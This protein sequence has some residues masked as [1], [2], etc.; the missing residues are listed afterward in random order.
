M[1]A[2]PAGE[3]EFIGRCHERL[4]RMLAAFGTSGDIGCL[5]RLTARHGYAGEAVASSS[6]NRDGR[7]VDYFVCRLTPGAT[8][9]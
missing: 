7:Q 4:G 6:L 2:I 1:P 5:H 3:T 9:D 8:C